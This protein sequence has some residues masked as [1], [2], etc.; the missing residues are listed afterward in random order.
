MEFKHVTL[1]ESNMTE[2][3]P[4]VLLNF[5]SL[6]IAANL[7]DSPDKIQPGDK[8]PTTPK[9]LE[10]LNTNRPKINKTRIKLNE[11]IYAAKD[12]DSDDYAPAVQVS[13]P[14]KTC[15]VLVGKELVLRI[16]TIIR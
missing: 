13:I 16:N 8:P 1:I 12:T 6:N 10:P 15:S 9:Y 7:A 4:P 14:L 2:G 11:K 5:P 3:I